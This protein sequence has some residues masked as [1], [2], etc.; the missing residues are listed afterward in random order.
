MADAPARALLFGDGCPDCGERRVVL[1]Q[2]LPAIG[3]DFDWQQRDYD[4]F[5]IA[6]LEEIAARFPE[7]GDRWRPADMEVVLVEALA[8]VL[9]QLSD[10]LDRVHA[11]GFLDTARQP[12]SVRRL[13]GLIGYDPL[14]SSGIDHDPTDPAS[15]AAARTELARRWLD[16]PDEMLAAK[17]DG[18]RSIHRQRRMVTLA[19]YETTLAEHPLVERAHATLRWSGSWNTIDVAVVLINNTLLDAPFEAGVPAGAPAAALDALRQRVEAFHRQHSL[20]KP[21]WLATHSMRSL[22]S[23]FVEAYRMLGQDVRLLDAR[24]VPIDLAL[25][26]RIRPTHFRSE[27]RD[28]VRLVLGTGQDG[29]FRPGRLRFGED[30]HLSDVIEVVMA[31]DGVENLCVNRFKRLG[32]RHAD[33]TDQGQI[34]L[35]GTEIAICDGDSRLPERGVLR[36]SIEG[37]QVG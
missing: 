14:E 24:F 2:A 19:D 28:A 7:R 11:E 36:I 21:E 8:V 27:V 9:D 23:E 33:R 4:S 35:E 34:V 3:D 25:S 18:P 29:F 1:P 26:V 32:H 37:G 20:D 13:L 5:R 17:R 31:L 6:M 15:V 12:E 16:Y 10:M 22:V 30:L